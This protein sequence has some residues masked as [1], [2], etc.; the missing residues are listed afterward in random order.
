M[1]RTDTSA[2]VSV[3]RFFQFALLGLVTSGF[4][5]VAG[6]G[7]LDLPTIALTATGLLVRALIVCGLIRSGLS[8]R[9]VT[10]LA[11]SYVG[12]FA[13]DYFVLSHA[14]FL[15]ATVHLVFF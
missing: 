8:D 13:V 10:I 12:F 7:Y 9:T 6:S 15:T 2:A 11:V 14:D 5:A 3:E 1:A 4:L